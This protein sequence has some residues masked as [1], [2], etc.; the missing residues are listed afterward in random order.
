V[1][2]RRAHPE[3]KHGRRQPLSQQELAKRAGVS[4]GCLQAF[5][6]NTRAT[7]RESVQRIAAAVG[8]SLGELFAPDHAGD[9]ARV[10]HR[11]AG[12]MF[13]DPEESDNIEGNAMKKMFLRMLT[14]ARMAFW[15]DAVNHF[16]GR[17]D[18][19]ALDMIQELQIAGLE[20]LSNGPPSATSSTESRPVEMFPRDGKESPS[21]I[22]RAHR[23]KAGAR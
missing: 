10:Q 7:Q 22:A 1:A 13:D 17:R 23:R 4:P 14:P 11:F 18:P 6:N 9:V 21:A 19:A 2:Y 5:E 3:K 15:T 12:M 20:P 16:K 8:L